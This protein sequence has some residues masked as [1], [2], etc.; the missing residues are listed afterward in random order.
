MIA[1]IWRGTTL[2]SKAD[3]Y[4]QYLMATGLSD[5]QKTAGNK[6]VQI[7]RRV[8]DGRAE[9]IL[10]SFWESL[11]AIRNFAGE[12]IER[13]RYYPEDEQYLLA[14]EPEVEHYEVVFDK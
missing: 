14:F 11:D 2:E 13:A 6:E 1:R 12:N 4:L 9:F 10:V 7:L 8:R 3:E 5:Y